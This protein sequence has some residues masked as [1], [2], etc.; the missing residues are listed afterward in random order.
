MA[1]TEQHLILSSLELRAFETLIE[2][3]VILYLEIHYAIH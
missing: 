2:N 1:G 3:E